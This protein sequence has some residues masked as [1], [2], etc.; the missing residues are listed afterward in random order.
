MRKFVVVLS[1]V[2]LSASTVLAQSVSNVTNARMDGLGVQNWQVEDPYNIFINPAQIGNY[3]GMVNLEMGDYVKAGSAVAN[4]NQDE[5]ATGSQWGGANLGT[6]YGVWGIYLGRPYSG[7]LTSLPG[8]APTNNRFDLFY[9]PNGMPIGVYLSYANQSTE[10][11]APGGDTT[12][13]ATEIYLG[14]GG[15]FMGGMLDAALNLG[16]PDS[17]TEAGGVKVESDAGI[18]AAL[19]AR[20]RQDHEG[21]KYFY[22]VRLAQTDATVK[23]GEDNTGTLIGLDWTCNSKPNDA[24]LFIVGVGLQFTSSDTPNA[25]N[26]DTITTDN[27]LLPVN[28]AVEHQTFKRVKT[29]VGVSKAIYNSTSVDDSAADTTTDTV[30][31]G[32]ATV[33]AGLGMMLADNVELDAVLNQD[34]I[35]AGPYGISGVAETL[36]SKVSASVKF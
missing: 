27:I 14:V 21:G 16:L 2:L 32:A 24:T 18:N 34:F 28:A 15:V 10:V 17:S 9:A 19:I 3:K 5:I 23:D 8:T 11:S 7:P 6:S 30:A 35:F 36:S 12:D 33:S 4:P 13:E 29:R 20:L 31:D 26:T 22:T 1:A 25:T